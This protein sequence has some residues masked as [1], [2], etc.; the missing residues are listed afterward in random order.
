[1]QKVK[2]FSESTVEKLENKIS[3]YIHKSNCEIDHVAY[4]I[5]P[6]GTHCALVVIT[7]QKYDH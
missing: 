4:A 1:M 5:T 7:E 6:H 3:E 2:S